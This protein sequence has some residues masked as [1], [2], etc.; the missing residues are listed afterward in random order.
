MEGAKGKLIVKEN[1]LIRYLHLEEK[2][3]SVPVGP[4]IKARDKTYMK[5]RK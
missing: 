2:K 3:R 1:L 5:G 4:Q